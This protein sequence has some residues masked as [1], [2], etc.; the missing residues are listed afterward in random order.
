MK[1]YVL[2]PRARKD[3]DDICEYTVE[4]SNVEQAE[5]YLR[6][7]Q[8][9]IETVAADPKIARACDDIR[10]GY[11]KYPAGSHVLFFRITA[12]GINVVRILH[13]KMDFE[14]HI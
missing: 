14:R 2:S 10:P 9:A 5:I 11:W 4:H 8:R 12:K 3:I 7:I 6:Q 1:G 13:S